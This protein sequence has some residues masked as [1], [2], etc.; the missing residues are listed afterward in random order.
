MVRSSK[1]E[2]TL[3]LKGDFTEQSTSRLVP[4]THLYFTG[5]LSSTPPSP[6]T[7]PP[8]PRPPRPSP[9]PRR[10][11]RDALLRSW[12]PQKRSGE[13]YTGRVTRPKRRRENTDRTPFDSDPVHVGERV[14]TVPP[15]IFGP[16]GVQSPEQESNVRDGRSKDP[17]KKGLSMSHRKQRNKSKVVIFFWTTNF[18]T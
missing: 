15:L 4:V 12:S 13:V 7:P 18:D 10:R 3:L 9:H 2:L 17:I 6:P 1:P 5:S 16:D 8:P 11:R 14:S